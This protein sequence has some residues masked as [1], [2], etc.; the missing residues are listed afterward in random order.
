MLAKV[1][2]ARSLITSGIGCSAWRAGSS[3]SRRCKRRKFATGVVQ[4]ATLPAN[5][6]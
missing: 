2:I 3:A 5:V 4:S 6:W 1:S